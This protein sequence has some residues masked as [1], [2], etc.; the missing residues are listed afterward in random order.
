MYGLVLFIVLYA[1]SVVV[2]LPSLPLNLLAGYV[3]GAWVG[4]LYV[5]IAVTLGSLISFMLARSVFGQSLSQK[6]KQGS[7]LKL[8][9]S[10]EKHGW[11][12]VAFVRLNPIFPTG[13]INYLFGLTPI[14]FRAFSIATFIFLLPPAVIVAYLGETFQ[15]FVSGG[16]GVTTWLYRLM[17]L[18]LLA[19]V[20]SAVVWILRIYFKRAGR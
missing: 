10:L 1:T 4:G 20:L 7:F 3:W 17:I 13:P 19:T 8:A 12:F 9:E 16:E 2:L 15:T 18:S 6:F 11:K 14:S 5:A